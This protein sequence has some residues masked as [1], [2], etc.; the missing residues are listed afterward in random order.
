MRI[1]IEKLIQVL[2]LS[3]LAWSLWC[4]VASFWL[5]DKNRVVAAK[6]ALLAGIA[7][8]FLFSLGPVASLIGRPLEYE[9]PIQKMESYPTAGAI[10]VLG[11]SVSGPV[12]PR[13]SIEE[14]RGARVL[15]AARLYKNRKAPLILVSGGVPYS[16]T[17]GETRRE[18][19]DMHDLLVEYGVPTS[20]ILMEAESR[21]TA[22]NAAQTAAL[23]KSKGIGKILLVTSA[24]HV[25]R[26]ARLFRR[27]NLEVIPVPTSHEVVFGGPVDTYVPNAPSLEKSTRF[28]KEFFGRAVGR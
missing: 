21:T 16:A 1:V 20:A 4:F 5:L 10:V 27:Q 22:E 23:L 15:S 28:L 6:R 12:P 26:G 13:L 19:G 14:G 3:P 9:Y 24:Y 2:F 25:G 18:A 11:G 7:V 8:L 17:S